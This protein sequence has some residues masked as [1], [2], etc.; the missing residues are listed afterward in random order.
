MVDP[1][2]TYLNICSISEHV[3]SS[4]SS[5]VIFGNVESSRNNFTVSITHIP[6]ADGIQYLK[7]MQCS[8]AGLM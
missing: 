6:P 8:I 4:W 7:H 3:C 1:V 2:L 5:V